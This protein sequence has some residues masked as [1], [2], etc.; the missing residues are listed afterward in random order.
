[1]VTSS[2]LKGVTTYLSA[3]NARSAVFNDDLTLIWTN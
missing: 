2:V 1:M 3:L